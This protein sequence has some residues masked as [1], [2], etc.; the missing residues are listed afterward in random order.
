MNTSRRDA[1]RLGLCATASFVAV[2]S[3]LGAAPRAAQK[4]QLVTPGYDDSGWLRRDLFESALG[5]S[6]VVRAEKSRVALQLVGVDDPP[7]RSGAV[8]DENNFT[9]VFSGPRLPRLPQG[10][11]PVD[12]E[13]LGRFELFLVPGFTTASGTSYTATFNRQA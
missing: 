9:I 10:T 1:I 2:D 8:G 3:L 6:F 5:E 13:S 11:Y 7:R 4:Q 12:C